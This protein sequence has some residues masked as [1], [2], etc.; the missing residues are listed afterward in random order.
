MNHIDAQIVDRVALLHPEIFEHLARFSREQVGFVEP[1]LAR[2]DREMHFYVAYLDHL[3]RL[4]RSGL[5]FCYPT[6]STTHHEVSARET[7]DLALAGKLVW[8]NA[9]VVRNDFSL[10]DPERMLVVTGPNQGGKTTFA[11]TFGQLHHLAGLGCPVPGREAVLLVF[12][13]LF[14]HFE[15]EE[16]TTGAHGKLED[17]LIRVRNIL[18]AATSRSIVI[19]NEIFSSTSLEDSLF[20]GR[21]VLG[22]LIQRDTTAVCVTF[23]EE[24]STLGE[25]TVSL[26]AGSDPRDP[27]V[28]TFK[29]ERRRADGLAHA[30]AVAEKHRVTYRFLKERLGR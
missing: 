13:Q 23:L 20:L 15:R 8:Q 19:L 10:H 4:R 7:F 18:D 26:V 5:P 1:T 2:F 25:K 24:L 21:E 17:E 6:V 12:D 9:A 28:R 14:T 16:D 27:T 22:R 29:I 30:I 3:D 11:R